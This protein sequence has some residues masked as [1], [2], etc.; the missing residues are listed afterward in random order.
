[1]N[2]ETQN[3]DVLALMDEAVCALQRD[4]N[5][6]EATDLIAASVAVAELIEIQRRL[7]AWNRNVN[8]SGTELGEICADAEVALARIGGAA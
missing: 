6:Q 1:M 4:G 5:N 2:N 3:V 8:G 7:V